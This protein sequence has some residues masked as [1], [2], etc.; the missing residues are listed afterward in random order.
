MAELAA[1]GAMTAMLSDMT[2]WVWRAIF[3]MENEDIADGGW[4][5]SQKLDT[6]QIVE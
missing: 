5:N 4:E 2:V 1:V 6:L 3:V